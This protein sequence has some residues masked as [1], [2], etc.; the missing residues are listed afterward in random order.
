MTDTLTP[1]DWVAWYALPDWAYRHRLD[2]WALGYTLCVRS[3]MGV[4]MRPYAQPVSAFG[5][6]LPCATCLATLEQR[7]WAA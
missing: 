7:G 3:V 2:P 4:D 1:L 6:L 5:P